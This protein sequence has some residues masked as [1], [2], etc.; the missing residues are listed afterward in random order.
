MLPKYQHIDHTADAGFKVYGKSLAELFANA[1][2]GLFDMIAS[3]DRVE[4]KL[5]RDV[6]VAAQDRE[7]LLVKWLSELN[8]LF[9]TRHEIY[10][11]FDVH[12]IS[13]TELRARVRGEKLDYDRHEIYTEIKAVTYHHLYI[14]ETPEGW[15]AQVIFDL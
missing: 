15:E 9:V 13:D 4:L 8:F 12:E 2:E 14:K 7:E 10:K 11:A 5:E 3:L 6:S 1:A